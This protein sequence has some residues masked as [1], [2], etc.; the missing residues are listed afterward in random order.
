MFTNFLY[1]LV[2]VL[3]LYGCATK[4]VYTGNYNDSAVISNNTGPLKMVKLDVKAANGDCLV[5]EAKPERTLEKHKIEF[6]GAF[7]VTDPRQKAVANVISSLD[8]FQN[9]KFSMP[10]ATKF[11]F[12]HKA[13]V[14]RTLGD[15]LIE[16]N[17]S[18]A[19]A[20]AMRKPE[21]GGTDNQ[22]LIAHM[23]AYQVAGQRT[24]YKDFRK[25]AALQEKC[26]VSR[27]AISKRA[28]S[29]FAEAFAA[30]LT[31]P[32]L[33]NISDCEKTFAYMKDFF[34]EESNEITCASRQKRFNSQ[35]GSA[36]QSS[37]TAK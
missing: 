8:R 1:A 15:S 31:N 36:D 9:K 2:F 20:R 25:K 17:P 11:K 5:R 22:A 23:L 14:S 18:P 30:Y 12:S 26:L 21:F 7:D 19:S 28:L 4:Q 16:V 24:V 33:L 3:F 27:Y 10:T 34:G 35:A 32:D 6:E 29:D 37:G 13:E